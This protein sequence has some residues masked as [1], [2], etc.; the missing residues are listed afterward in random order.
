MLF[1]SELAAFPDHAGFLQADTKAIEEWRRRLHTY[2]PGSKIGVSWRSQ[3]I[4]P[5][6]E[7][8]MMTVDEVIRAASIP[9]AILINLQYDDCREELDLLERRTGVRVQNFT[10]LNQKNEIDRVAALIRAL[11]AVVSAGTSVAALAGALGVPLWQFSTY[12]DPRATFGTSYTP[13]FPR[14]HFIERR[15]PSDWTATIGRIRHELLDYLGTDF[16]LKGRP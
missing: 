3:S 15:W 13:W 6:K 1:R 10:D 7:P 11:D 14:V 2:G 12:P 8:F 16:N 5:H 4:L 9:G